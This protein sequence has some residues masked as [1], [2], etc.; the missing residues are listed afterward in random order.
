MGILSP[1]IFRCCLP[2]FTGERVSENDE[3]CHI[4]IRWEKVAFSL[5]LNIWDFVNRQGHIRTRAQEKKMVI[6]LSTKAVNSQCTSLLVLF[7]YSTN[8]LI[9][10][11]LQL[12]FGLDR[13][14]SHLMYSSFLLLSTFLLG[15]FNKEYQKEGVCFTCYIINFKTDNAYCIL[16]LKHIFL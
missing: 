6:M 11:Q 1:L 15:F 2:C 4:C 5:L 16:Q 7:L 8:F 14:D 10:V 3:S 9:S 13:R 12:H